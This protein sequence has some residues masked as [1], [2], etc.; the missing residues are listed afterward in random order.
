MSNRHFANTFCHPIFGDFADDDYGEHQAQRT[1][2]D[3]GITVK[4]EYAGREL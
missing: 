1:V 4:D 2:I 3:V